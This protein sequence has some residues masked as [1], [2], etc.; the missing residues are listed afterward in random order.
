MRLLN[1][2]KHTQTHTEKKS[3]PPPNKDTPRA[4]LCDTKGGVCYWIQLGTDLACVCSGS[5][6]TALP[7]VN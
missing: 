7:R 4:E 3:T 5:A 1:N 6:N 2:N